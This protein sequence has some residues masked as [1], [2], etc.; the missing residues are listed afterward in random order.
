MTEPPYLIEVDHIQ[1]LFRAGFVAYGEW[2]RRRSKALHQRDRPFPEEIVLVS[3]R[4]LA[5]SDLWQDLAI[6]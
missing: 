5:N 4:D 1:R 3:S 6:Q 2:L